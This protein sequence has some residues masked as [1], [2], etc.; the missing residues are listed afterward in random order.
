MCHTPY[1]ILLLVVFSP[2]FLF[3]TALS[4]SCN[5]RNQ[6]RNGMVGGGRLV[7]EFGGGGGGD[8]GVGFRLGVGVSHWLVP[9]Q[10][11]V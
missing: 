9:H 11:G 3:I 8:L 1:Y 4:L 10:R 2:S 6:S 7:K 5:G